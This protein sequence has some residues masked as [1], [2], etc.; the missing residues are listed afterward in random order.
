METIGTQVT[1]KVMKKI[2]RETAGLGTQ[3]TRANIIQTLFQRK[4]IHQEK[5]LL[6]ATALGCNLIDAVPS[7]IKDP[8]LTAQWEQQLDDIA[9]NKGQDINGFLKQQIDLLKS[10]VTQVKTPKTNNRTQI[11][12]TNRNK[13]AASK[14]SKQVKVGDPCP[15][16]NNA[17]ETRSAIRGRRVGQDYIGCSHFP[18]CRFYYWP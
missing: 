16:C 9:N 11:K 7:A 8:L 2:L 15:E 12:F 18:D 6:K 5:K 4:F 10:I 17:L 14:I 13:T 1:D 3:A